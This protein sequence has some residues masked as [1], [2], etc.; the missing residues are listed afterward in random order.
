MLKCRSHR[1]LVRAGYIR[2]AA[3]GGYT[4]LPLGK[5]VV[6]RV[7]A[8]V[9]DEMVRIGGQEVSF[10]SLLPR[11][12][13]EASGRWTEYGDEVFRLK[14]VAVPTTCS[15]RRTRRCSPRWSRTSA[16]PTGTIR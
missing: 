16:R 3:S 7:T 12:P 15:G 5:L 4:M 8:V 13:Y 6:D 11:E 1:L 10:P 9:R 2:R 14:T